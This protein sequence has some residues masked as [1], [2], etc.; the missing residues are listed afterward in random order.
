MGAVTVGDIIVT[1]LKNISVVGGNVMHAMKCTDTGYTG[2]G[3]AYFS[4][5]EKAAVKAW[6]RHIRMTLNLIVPFGFVRFVFVDQYGDKRIEK[7]GKNRFSRLTVPPG[8]WFGFEGLENNDSLVLN[9]A[10][11]IH[12]P[13]EVERMEME[14]IDF[15]WKKGR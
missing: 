4:I 12:E 1:P 11:I 10:D 9:I 15:D 6:K 14:A 13:D 2:F 8:I 5:V 7:I 3:E